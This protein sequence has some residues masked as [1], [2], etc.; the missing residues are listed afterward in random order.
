[1]TNIWGIVQLF[2]V[3]SSHG[4]QASI[5]NRVVV[6]MTKVIEKK[7]SHIGME[8]HYYLV[9]NLPVSLLITGRS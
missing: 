7:V 6:A 9:S 5:V 1:M 3:E 8:E 2:V 4:T